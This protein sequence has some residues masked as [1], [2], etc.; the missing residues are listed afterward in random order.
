MNVHGEG[1]NACD[2]DIVNRE[3]GTERRFSKTI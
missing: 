3:A 2:Q 1:I